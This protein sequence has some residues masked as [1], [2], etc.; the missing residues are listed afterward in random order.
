MY[1]TKTLKGFIFGLNTRIRCHFAQ[2]RVQRSLEALDDHMLRDLGI[3]RAEI[4]YVIDGGGLVMM[5]AL[6]DLREVSMGHGITADALLPGMTEMMR[7][8]RTNRGDMQSEAARYR[9]RRMRTRGPRRRRGIEADRPPS[10][11]L[12][13]V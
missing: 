9:D 11:S 8:L 4:D 10:P 3:T 5:A 7:L 2:A 13:S 1:W 12:R 6:P